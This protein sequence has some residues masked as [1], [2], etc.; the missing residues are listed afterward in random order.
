MQTQLKLLQLC[1]SQS[2]FESRKFA[3][4]VGATVEASRR[5][6]SQSGRGGVQRQTGQQSGL[7]K[8]QGSTLNM[9]GTDG[10]RCRAACVLF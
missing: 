1:P 6:H 5:S 9:E 8:E 10:G 2:S 4:S 3:R 7:Q